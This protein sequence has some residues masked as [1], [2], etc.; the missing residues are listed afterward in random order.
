MLFAIFAIL[1]LLSVIFY[2][3]IHIYQEMLYEDDKKEKKVYVSE[4]IA[5]SILFISTALLLLPQSFEYIE[6]IIK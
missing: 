5:L 3:F 6:G 1:G 2:K 4:T